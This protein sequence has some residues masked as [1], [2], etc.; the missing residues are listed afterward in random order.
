MLNSRYSRL[1]TKLITVYIVMSIIPIVCISI[2]S[3]VIYYQSIVKESNALIEQNAK[4]HELLIKERL[5][6]QK[7]F[8]Y[9]MVAD[10]T[11]IAFTDQWNEASND[12]I[13]EAIISKKMLLKL[14]HTRIRST[15]YVKGMVLVTDTNDYIYYF[16]QEYY[17]FEAKWSNPS[18]RNDIY[19]QVATAKKTVL[20]P[21]QSCLDETPLKESMILVAYPIRDLVTKDNK[22]AL[23][24]FLDGSI[25]KSYENSEQGGVS[26]VIVD[27]NNI[28]LSYQ[29]QE[30]IAE[31]LDVLLDRKFSNVKNIR[32]KYTPIKDTSWTI[33]NLIDES[34]FLYKMEQ[35]PIVIL[36]IVLLVACFVHVILYFIFKRYI[37]TIQNIAYG[38]DNYQVGDVSVKIDI[39]TKDD[40]YIIATR[41]YQ[42]TQR[43]NELIVALNAKNAAV[44]QAIIL[45]KK[46][47]IKVLEAQI[48]PHFLYNTLDSINWMAIERDQIE[49]SNMLGSLGDLLRYSI[50]NIDTIVSL[51]DEMKW[52]E[53][54]VYLQK[55]RF[56][57]AF[58]LQVTLELGTRDFPIYKL[59]FQ[60]LIE[61]S[62][63]H[64][65]EAIK[66]GGVLS[67][68]AFLQN[69]DRLILKVK[70]N[71]KGMDEELVHQIQ[72]WIDSINEPPSES[73][74]I[75]NTINRL[76]LYYGG[77]AKIT[78]NSHLDKGTIFVLNI[79]RINQAEED[80]FYWKGD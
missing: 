72:T 62:I 76:R 46:A 44:Q 10:P 8:L 56:S 69:Q 25:L 32:I 73:I 7:K 13:T 9:E 66:S 20:F 68:H 19:K 70:D 58:E 80:I 59:L 16:T 18:Y 11:V 40:L 38:I 48:N 3:F 27:Q 45:R 79:P 77:T 52:L 31:P 60:P 12:K 63:L 49:L 33:I 67:I 26:T 75:L 14:F 34:V 21:N 65:F 28:I 39:D 74:G 42:M 53:N 55:E 5:L 35:L 71:G 1:K 17:M 51:D 43:I 78:V 50:S 15:S 57:D 23:F 36:V 24:L 22:G 47:E 29:D 4:Q 6:I 54:Y 30:Y 64:G 37:S 61:N 41:F 2:L